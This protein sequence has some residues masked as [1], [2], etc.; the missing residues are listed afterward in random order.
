MIDYKKDFKKLTWG[1]IGDICCSCKTPE[2]AKEFLDFYR[3]ENPEGADHNLG[4]LFGYYGNETRERLYSLFPVN[5]PIFG[6]GFGRGNDPT[7]KEAFEAGVKAGN[8]GGNDG[9][10]EKTG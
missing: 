8:K 7:F 3:K 2:E 5:H 9:M 6:S 1:Q 10:V 4:Y